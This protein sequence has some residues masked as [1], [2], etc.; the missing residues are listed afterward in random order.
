L[1]C[2]DLSLGKEAFAVK[3]YADNSLPSAALGKGFAAKQLSAVV[4]YRFWNMYMP[5]IQL[6]SS[7]HG[8]QVHLP[9]GCVPLFPSSQNK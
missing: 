1:P 7:L 8:K 4:I 9:L 6:V 3:G 2:V 5:F